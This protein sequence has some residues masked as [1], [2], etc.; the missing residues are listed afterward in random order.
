VVGQDWLIREG[1]K[2]GERVVVEGFQKITAG[3]TVK[4]MDRTVPH[5]SETGKP[6]DPDEAG[7]GEAK[8]Q[9]ASQ[10]R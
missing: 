8:R 5:E 7:D 6:H 2:A 3:I 9:A 4:P 1:L 10:V